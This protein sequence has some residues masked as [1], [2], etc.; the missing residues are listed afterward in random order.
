MMI[1]SGLLVRRMFMVMHG[2]AMN[3]KHVQPKKIA[4]V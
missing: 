3:V 2:E 1:C 4:L